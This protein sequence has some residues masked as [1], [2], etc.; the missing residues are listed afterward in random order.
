MQAITLS[1]AQ[2]C[3]LHVFPN[4]NCYIDTLLLGAFG[5]EH[6][7]I[8]HNLVLTHTD[9]KGWKANETTEHRRG[10]DAILVRSENFL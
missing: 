7:L 9:A 6:C 8:K 4:A 1:S 10:F 5:Q 2:Q 3:D